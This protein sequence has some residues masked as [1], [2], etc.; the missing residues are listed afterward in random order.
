ML[1]SVQGNEVLEKMWYQFRV[2]YAQQ[3]PGSNLN[4]AERAFLHHILTGLVDQNNSI[5]YG[6][7]SNELKEVEELIEKIR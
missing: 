4:D 6:I 5:T 1:L 3:N 7:N 2:V